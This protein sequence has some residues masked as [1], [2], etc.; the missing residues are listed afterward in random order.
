MAPALKPRPQTTA[1]PLQYQSARRPTK[2][3][4]VIQESIDHSLEVFAFLMK[5]FAIGVLL[6]LLRTLI[7]HA[8]VLYSAACSSATSKEDHL[9]HDDVTL[10]RGM[11][12]E[13]PSNLFWKK[14]EN[15]VEEST[16]R[17]KGRIDFPSNECSIYGF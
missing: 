17:S 7:S 16:N 1:E 12:A 3:S 15:A 13:K 4:P 5:I 10:Q 2:H 14:G 6:N 8:I 11:A 9:I